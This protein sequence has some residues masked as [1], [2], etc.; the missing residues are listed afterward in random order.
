MT[1]E[2]KTV[3]GYA[4][5]VTDHIG[6]IIAA[7]E[8]YSFNP[9][10]HDYLT[11]AWFTDWI[12][13]SKYKDSEVLITYKFWSGEYYC[14]DGVEYDSGLDIVHEILLG[15]GFRERLVKEIKDMQK[16]LL[17]DKNEDDFYLD[18]IVVEKEEY[19]QRLIEE[20]NSL[21]SEYEDIY[22]EEFESISDLVKKGEI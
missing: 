16:L 20:I 7:K 10:L 9:E 2:I 8:W 12:E 17:E 18:K 15:N 6:K 14:W 21:I 13:E 3:D 4:R 1:E 5:V 22:N 19:Q 11:N